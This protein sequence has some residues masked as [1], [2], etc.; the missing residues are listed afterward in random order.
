[1][2]PDL[3]QKRLR[4]K[5]VTS[6][7]TESRA[8]V[9]ISDDGMEIVKLKVNTNREVHIN[10]G[11]DIK[12]WSPKSPFLYDLKIKIDSGDEVISYFGMRKIEMRK[13][14]RFQRIFLNNELLQFQV[15]P[16]DQGYWP[17]GILTPPTEEAMKWDLEKTLEMGFNMVRKH[18]KIG[19]LSNMF[20]I[21]YS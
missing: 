10:L 15:G 14:G 12:T 11:D 6:S 17:E 9:I 18:I 19:K 7:R 3:D 4:L 21:Y 5:I 16:L 8:E 13:V 2:V 20:S 1:M